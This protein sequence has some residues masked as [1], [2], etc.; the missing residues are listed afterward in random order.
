MRVFAS[1]FVLATALDTLKT[2]HIPGGHEY[3]Q[4][5]GKEFKGLTKCNEGLVCV[6][7]NDYYS[8]CMKTTCPSVAGTTMDDAF[9]G[10]NIIQFAEIPGQFDNTHRISNLVAA[11]VAGDLADTL[12]SPGP[13]TIFAPTDKA[14]EE[15]PAGVVDNLLKP[16]NKAALVSL[17]NY[18]VL[19]KQ[20][21]SKDWKPA[22]VVKTVEGET[23][24]V[25]VDG[26]GKTC[27]QQPLPHFPE[28][29]FICVLVGPSLKDLKKQAWT[30]YNKEF[31]LSNAAMY[32]IDGV[33][34][35]PNLSPTSTDILV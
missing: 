18:H 27:P 23:L 25:V 12:T 13:F 16:E 31:L 2:T 33:L 10:C 1:S 5:G 26:T 17:L 32:V 21:Q 6:W 28:R 3:A 34:L 9:K 15:L 24:H 14:F 20:V 7:Q 19:P 29:T 8:Q 35:P 4:C 22:Q 11:V 30:F